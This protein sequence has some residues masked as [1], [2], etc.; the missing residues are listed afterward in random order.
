MGGASITGSHIST[1]TDS[2]LLLRYVE[3]FGVMKRG[4]TVLKMRGSDHDKEIREFNID[5][6][7]MHLGHA[8]RHVT[9]ILA[10]A[11]VHVSPGDLERVWSQHEADSPSMDNG[12]A[13]ALAIPGLG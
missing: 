2:I 11:P 4:M 10:G 7:G 3:A 5:A 12:D 1:L 9:G 8:F 13:K 6:Q